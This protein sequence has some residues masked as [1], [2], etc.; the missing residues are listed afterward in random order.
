[1]VQ[2]IPF[3]NDLNLAKMYHEG[4]NEDQ[5]YVQNLAMF[6]TTFFATHLKTVENMGNRE[7]L[8]LG[9][10]YLLK[11]SLV[12]DREVFKVC[13]E[14]WNKF[15]SG[16]Y[17]EYPFSH[18][19]ET[20][21]MLGSIIQTNS[22]RSMYIEI[23]S[24]LRHVMIQKM[25]KPEEVLVV[26]DENGEV[27]REH[28]KETDTITLY[29]SMRECLVYLTHLDCEDTE[30]IMT[31]KL[32]RQFDGSE[33]SWGNLN[34]LCWAIGSISGAM[35]EETEKKFLVA[36][37]RDLLGLC[38]MKRG[39]DNK[40]IVASNIMYIVGQYPRF[41][42]AHWKFL[43]T[44]VNKLFE[45]MHETH[46][47][48]QDM[49]CDT[50]IKIA[51]KCRNHFVILQKDE[52][53]PFL[54]E[55]IESLSTIIGDLQPSQVHTFYEALGYMV[56]AQKDP[57]VAARQ[58]L[59]MMALPNQIW[60]SIISAASKNMAILQSSDNIKQLS[61]IL[62]TNI[63]ACSSVGPAFITQLG[64]IYMDMLS[65]YKAISGIV[66][67]SVRTQGLIATKTPLVRGLRGV[68]K[69]ILRLVDAFIVKAE[70]IPMVSDSL[71]PPLFEAILNDYK[72]NVEPARD[73]EVLAVTATII[74]KCKERLCDKIPA[75]LDAV[76]E[77]TLN[78]INKDFS[79]YPDLRANFFKLIAE[80][81]AN[82]FDSLLRLPPTQFKLI[83]DSVVWAFK[84]THR[85]IAE[86]GLNICLDLLNNVEKAAS[87]ITNAFYQTYFLTLLQDVFYVLTDTDHKSGFKL[88]SSILAHFFGIVESGKL[89]APLFNIGTNAQFDN[90]AMLSEYVVNLLKNA[91]PHLQ[92]SQLETFV[93][94]LFDLNK[95]ITTFKLHLRDF[96]IQL[97]EFSGDNAELFLEEF[98]LEQERKK[99]AEMDAAMR[100]PGIIKPHD[101]PDEFDD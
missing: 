24:S 65:L 27:V 57:N 78:M 83:I 55:I 10:Q 52:N 11:I 76:F 91:F 71:S 7:A 25:V 19:G 26:E 28:I 34:K 74:S 73:S 86:T 47:G 44:V 8:I 82:C 39:K 60:D 13:L 51:Q 21:L 61:S 84:H 54:D 81:N 87:P 98:E 9:F 63:S 43:K 35:N 56:Q 1:M 75:I 23:L 95:D 48:V 31:E 96:L 22:R 30:L 45:F 68:K 38:E 36:V 66:S 33:W 80:I 29:K 40:A 58:I 64:K 50:F 85:D 88:Q 53:L 67:E 69:D 42:K 72:A 99:K 41:L 32:S 17:A 14:F 89:T 49:A 62:K 59:S 101:K 6:L 77:C 2:V 37:I 79:E 4:N 94:G 15:V 92:K 18:V 90:K 46:E 70:D 97:K 12:D 5:K 93:K 16:L 100:V 3:T 20:P